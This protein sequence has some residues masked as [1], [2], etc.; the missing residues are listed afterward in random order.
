[1]TDQRNFINDEDSRTILQEAKDCNSSIIGISDNAS[2]SSQSTNSLTTSLRFDFDAALFRSH[3]YRTA[4]SSSWQRATTTVTGPHASSS[5]NAQQS[6]DSAFPLDIPF[7][8]P[9]RSLT[10]PT[11]QADESDILGGSQSVERDE[12][13]VPSSLVPP[14]KKN[15][16]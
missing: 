8:N 5:S 2:I 10:P 16:G 1:L 9:S 13:P 3:A 14:N 11:R 4:H 12:D 7:E 15:S 6:R